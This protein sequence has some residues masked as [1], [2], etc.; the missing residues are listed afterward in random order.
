LK[1]YLSKYT[2]EFNDIYNRFCTS[3]NELNEVTN[4]LNQKKKLVYNPEILLNR[5]YFGSMG[6]L[7]NQVMYLGKKRQNLIFLIK[8][9]SI[10]LRGYCF[11]VEGCFK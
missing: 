4:P 11:S 10:F 5:K 2:F 8:K 6:T 7:M 1:A 3:N 9:L